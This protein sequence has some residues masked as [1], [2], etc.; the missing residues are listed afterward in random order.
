M[1]D[2]LDG[3]PQTAAPK[4]RMVRPES[5][6]SLF[7]ELRFRGAVLSAATGFLIEGP[8]GP[9]LVTNWH[10][11]SGRN[12]QTGMVLSPTGGI[13]DEVRIVHMDP[14]P[15]VGWLSVV[16]PLL[17]DSGQ[18][19][20]FEHPVHGPKVDCVALP[21][22]QLDGVG[23]F[24][25]GLED[26]LH[27]RTNPGDVVSVVGFPFGLTGGGPL[28]LWATGFVASELEVDRDGLPLFLIDCRARPGQ[29][30][31]AVLRNVPGDSVR[32]RDGRIESIDEPGSTLL[33]IYSGR[34]N[35]QSDLGMVWKVSAIAEIIEAMPAGA[36]NPSSA[37]HPRDDPQ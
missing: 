33:G 27:M 2:I 20:W 1:A 37:D 10:S 3:E 24:P 36:F 22:T 19:R 23:V 29:S 9:V 16:E 6:K 31:S 18:P 26:L 34:V 25:H 12:S 7:L 35:E 14:G 8:G 4:Q 17:D 5:C 13:P 11:V 32:W 30:G 28:A 15:K 21:L